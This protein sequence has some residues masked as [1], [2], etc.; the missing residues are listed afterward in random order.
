MLGGIKTEAFFKPNPFFDLVNSTL[1][2]TLAL[3][4]LNT[5]MIVSNYLMVFH[6]H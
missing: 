6:F 4:D 3:R 1:K 5:L 2:L